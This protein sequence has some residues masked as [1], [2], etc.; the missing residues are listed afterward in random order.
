MRALRWILVGFVVLLTA[1]L[2]TA[3]QGS[4]SVE[5]T[6][7]GGDP[8]S[9][10]YSPLD[11]IDKGNVS[12]LQIAWRRPSVDPSLTP[13][14]TDFTSSNNFRSTPLMV[15]GVLYS[16]NGIGLVEAFDP[17]T[18]K[19]VWVQEPFRDE[20][21]LGLRGDSARGLAYWSGGAD[22]RL[23]AIHGEYLV[24]LDPRTGKP[25]GAFG[26]RGRVNL[27]LGLGPRA[28]DYAWT[29]VPQVCRDVVMVGL[30]IGG[31]VSDRPMHAEA[32]PGVVQAFDVRTGRPRW[33]FNPIPHPGEIGNDS[34]ENDSWAY[35]GNA[36][37]WSLMSADEEQ[38]LAYLPMTAPTNDMYG[39]H[40]LGDNLFANSLVCVKCLTGERV[41][42]YQ[43]VH[44]DLW[45]FDLPAAPILADIR[46][47]GRPV[48]AVVQLTKQAF[49]FVFD[50]IT[51]TPV[52]PI[53]ERPVPASDTPGERTARTQ[54][55]PTRP[56]AF[57]RQGISE[58]DLIDFTP[59]LHAEAVALLKHYRIGPLFT[60]PTLRGD[61]PDGIR[62]TIQLPG[63]VGGAD[64]QGGAFDPET[65]M[66]YVP[67]I[68]GPFTADIIKGDPQKSNLR[69]VSGT[70]VWT[71]GPGFLPLLKPPY[72]RITAI[73]L[74]KGTQAWMV[75]NGEGPRNH[76]LLKALNLPWLGNPGRSAP[77]L[78]RTLLFVGEGDPVMAA[79][80]SR[81]RP[82]MNPALVPGAGG[83]KFRAYDKAT[84]DRLWE[85]ELPTGTTGAP[86]TYMHQGKQYIVV[87]VAGSEADSAQFVALSLAGDV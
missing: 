43:L 50:R 22:R 68:T 46:V 56:P 2:V 52:W 8:G 44:H 54:P 64:W 5:W 16:S 82:E 36:N 53:E 63:S 23:F 1:G 11:Q 40:R 86:M 55:F 29:G 58:D 85:I 30:G 61:G 74:N 19:T 20:P 79:L 78:T 69:Y 71:A 14:V 33:S 26:D 4:R 75:P 72:G 17:A 62:G 84:G 6:S 27:R 3:Q 9:T 76:P 80:G 70:R 25:V 42:H 35:S 31:S 12:R 39:G 51:G 15:G 24:A 38:G 21:G 13:G 28:T 77:L 67:S 60:P 48:K 83:K 66:L 45:D 32:V 57:D 34:W 59:E 41:W 10:K 7:Y 73:D 81:L 65:G 18:G 87:A 49:A 37:L 47:D